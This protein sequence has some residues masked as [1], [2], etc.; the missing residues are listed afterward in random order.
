MKKLFAESIVMFA[1]MVRACW[2]VLLLILIPIEMLA[3]ALT[4]EGETMRDFVGA[5]RVQSLTQGVFGILAIAVSV[6]F[7]AAE[8]AQEKRTCWQLLD[9][10]LACW[11]RFFKTNLLGGLVVIGL[12]F[13][14]VVP[15]I[16]WAGFYAFTTYCVVIDGMRPIAALAESK[17]LVRGAWWE[18]AGT[19]V[20]LGLGA[21]VL[22][23]PIGIG[24]DLASE[25]V[26]AL[27]ADAEEVPMRIFV[28][29]KA[30]AILGNVSSDVVMLFVSVG[31]ALYYF[32]RKREVNQEGEIENAKADC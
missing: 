16:V 25:S 13:C 11:G 15:G 10:A 18:V 12:L 14:L 28:L 5:W 7:V 29:T 30:I 3:T 27:M 4:P 31:G 17:R 26:T 1:R 9:E 21:V 2:P 23:M 6:R 19:F 22:M 20:L 24:F 8:R 32:R